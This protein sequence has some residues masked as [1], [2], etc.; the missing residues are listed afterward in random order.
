MNR[1]TLLV[2]AG[3][4]T[5]GWIG[6][7]ALQLPQMRAFA[8]LRDTELPDFSA[9]P[10]DAEAERFLGQVRNTWLIQ[11]REEPDSI[12]AEISAVTGVDETVEGVVAFHTFKIP[13][14]SLFNPRRNKQAAV[15]A[16]T[17]AVAMPVSIDDRI[18]AGDGICFI[19]LTGRLV[20]VLED[21]K[22]G[23]SRTLYVEPNTGEP[24]AD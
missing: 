1:R 14:F 9:H 20:E 3:L 6:W 24:N 4:V 11:S 15:M 21:G 17:Q 16:T 19:K 7:L 13:N 22:D 10:I 23:L 5:L 8:K 18:Y 12:F 2:I